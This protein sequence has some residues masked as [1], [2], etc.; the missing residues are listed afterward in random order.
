MKT[1][2]AFIQDKEVEINSQLIKIMRFFSF[3]NK[4][5]EKE[6]CH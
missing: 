5:I 4:V 3:G 1:K 2:Q 6:N